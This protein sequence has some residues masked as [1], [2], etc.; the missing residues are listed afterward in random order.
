MT[1]YLSGC[2]KERESATMICMFFETA[3]ILIAI[4][5][6]YLVIGDSS[7]ECEKPDN[8]KSNITN[9]TVTTHHFSL[10][11]RYLTIAVIFASTFLI[12]F[13]LICFGVKERTGILFKIEVEL[14]YCLLLFSY[15]ELV[16]QMEESEKAKRFKTLRY[17][18]SILSYRPFIIFCFF[19][20]LGN[21]AILVN[22][23][24][25]VLI[26]FLIQII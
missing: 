5:S 2:K 6:Q 24:S 16:V 8:F 21:L 25:D 11:E 19:S 1:M 12:A 14:F 9:T 23:N 17:L 22:Q 13:L 26:F 7:G 10:H 3:S 20:M 4:L 18:K 15:L